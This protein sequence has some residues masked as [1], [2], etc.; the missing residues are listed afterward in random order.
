MTNKVKEHIGY[1]YLLTK[2][3][4]CIFYSFGIDYIPQE[5]LSKIS[6]KSITLKAKA[7]EQELDYDFI[8]IDPDQ[9]DCGIF[10]AINEIFRH[11]KQSSNQFTKKRSYVIIKI[12]A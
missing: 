9:N 11:I 6:D 5:V 1:Y 10:K 7:I 8:R 2:I 12:R 3:R 4:L